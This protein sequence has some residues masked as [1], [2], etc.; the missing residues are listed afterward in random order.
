MQCVYNAY[1]VDKKS[2]EGIKG[3][4]NIVLSCDY[5]MPRVPSG[6]K[7]FKFNKTERVTTCGADCMRLC[8][9]SVYRLHDVPLIVVNYSKAN[10]NHSIRKT[11]TLNQPR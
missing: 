2:S 3:R 1:A 11:I 5:K 9:L 4:S 6:R 8:I 7:Q 10:A